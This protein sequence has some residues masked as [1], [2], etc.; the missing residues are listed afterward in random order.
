VNVNLADVLRILQGHNSFLFWV[1]LAAITCGVS[2]FLTG[3]FIHVRRM[4]RRGHRQSRGNCTAPN[5]APAAPREITSAGHRVPAGS[6][7]ES[8]ASATAMSAGDIRSEIRELS[9]GSLPVILSRL[10][11]ATDRLEA[12]AG[13]MLASDHVRPESSLKHLADEVEYVFRASRH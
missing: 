7:T 5:R 8:A 9:S 10:R 11:Q 6:P 4:W 1:A 12:V 3:V 13:E 2:F